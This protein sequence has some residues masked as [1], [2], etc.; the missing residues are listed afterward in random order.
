MLT[1]FLMFK[2]YVRADDFADDDDKLASKLSAATRQVVNATGYTLDQLERIPYNE[3]PADLR[4]AI[5]M[6]GASL[7]AYAEDVNNSNL[8]VLP[9]AFMAMIKPYCKM[10]GG[11]LLEELVE[12][13]KDVE[14]ASDE[15]SSSNEDS[16]SL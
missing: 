2:K 16:S 1:D 8:G 9:L 3:F 4:E 6:R 12:K 5:Y 11:G 15:E 14:P 7:Y 13:Y 10:Y